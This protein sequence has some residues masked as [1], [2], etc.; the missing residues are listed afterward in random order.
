LSIPLETRDGELVYSRCRMFD[1]N[2]TQ[3]GH[4]KINYPVTILAPFLSHPQSLFFLPDS[5]KYR[6]LD[7]FSAA[8]Y[9]LYSW[10]E[11]NLRSRNM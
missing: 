6:L 4:D 9:F 3:V 11:H 7:I 1:V 2:F 10:E 8:Y 5:S